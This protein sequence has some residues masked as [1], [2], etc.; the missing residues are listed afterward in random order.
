M[1]AELSLAYDDQKHGRL[2]R[3]I[4]D[5]GISAMTVLFCPGEFGI[6]T[7]NFFGVALGAAGLH[8]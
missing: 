8:G 6:E 7:T 4:D 1:H 3:M 5:F 2:V